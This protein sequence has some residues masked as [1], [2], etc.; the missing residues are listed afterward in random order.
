MLEKYS[1]LLELSEEVKEIIFNVQTSVFNVSLFTSYT[2]EELEKCIK[3]FSADK[4]MEVGKNE[5]TTFYQDSLAN[6]KIKCIYES[7]NEEIINESLENYIFYL[8]KFDAFFAYHHKILKT[9]SD[10]F[11]YEDFLKYLIV[12]INFKKDILLCDEGAMYTQFWNSFLIPTVSGLLDE[13]IDDFLN[14]QNKT[15]PQIFL[16]YFFM[17]RFQQLGGIQK[18]LNLL[19]E[20]RASFFDKYF[21]TKNIQ[22]TNLQDRIYALEKEIFGEDYHTKNMEKL[23][24]LGFDP[25]ILN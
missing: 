13:M 9:Y 20:K 2:E 6:K 17:E 10:N 11:S 7:G 8:K 4:I 24:A 23:K 22:F 12:Y 14:S 15:I 3:Y 1:K 25:D 19:A 16:D 18:T 21:D 5:Y